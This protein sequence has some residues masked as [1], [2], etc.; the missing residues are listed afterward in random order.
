MRERTLAAVSEEKHLLFL[1]FDLF[2]RFIFFFLSPPSFVV[3]DFIGTM[4]SNEAF[5]L[6]LLLVAFFI[7]VIK[8]CLYV[9]VL[10]F[11]GNFLFFFFLILIFK[12]III[13]STFIPLFVFPTV[14]SPLQLIFNVY[15][16][17]LSTSI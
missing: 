5:E 15:K 10:Q 7:V 3:V 11:F 16:S 6:F 2:C 14:L 8:L 9:G 17:S 12:P 13:F 1:F 4:K